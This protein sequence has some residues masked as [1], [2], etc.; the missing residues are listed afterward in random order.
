MQAKHDRAAGVW[1]EA[2][3]PA[4]EIARRQAVLTTGHL[5]EWGLSELPGCRGQS[6]YGVRTSSG[7]DVGQT[8]EC[9]GTKF[10]VAAAMYREDKNPKYFFGLPKDTVAMAANDVVTSGRPPTFIQVYHAAGHSRWFKDLKRA[11]A[12]MEGYRAACDEIYCAWGGGETPALADIIMP[13][14]A[15]MA[16]VATS[17]VPSTWPYL[18]G[19][20]LQAGDAIVLLPSSGIHANGLSKARELGKRLQYGYFTK[21]LTGKTYGEALLTP[22]EFYVNIVVACIKHSIPLHYLVHITG[23]GWRKLMRYAGRP[24][25]YVIDRVPPVPAVLQFIQDQMDT[26]DRDM[27]SAFNM[28]AGFAMYLPQEYVDQVITL[29]ADIGLPGAIHAGNV[30][31]ADQSSVKIDPKGIVLE[32]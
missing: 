28:G 9:L 19:R 20:E 11:R 3:D 30:Y 17:V 16:V 24:Y 1:Y 23:H 18:D 4:V 22:T 25:E 21:L 26:T 14:Q 10:D 7:V 8:L 32:A 31:A 13:R 2:I 12:I 27:Y 29:A 15:D 6:Y 5:A